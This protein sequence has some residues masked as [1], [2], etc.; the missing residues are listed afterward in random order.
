MPLPH[1]ERDNLAVKRVEVSVPGGWKAMHTGARM[2]RSL[3]PASS[4]AHRPTQQH[5]GGAAHQ[6][7]RL[8]QRLYAADHPYGWGST[9]RV[10]KT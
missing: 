3:P 8:L 2:E 4:S 9:H 7:L 1:D 10:R 5:A 6:L